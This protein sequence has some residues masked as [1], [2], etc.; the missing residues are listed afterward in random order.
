MNEE[1]SLLREGSAITESR[2]R[3]KFN[4]DRIVFTDESLGKSM[5]CLENLLLQ[6]IKGFL[7]DEEGTRQRWA[8]S[9]KITE[10][11][12]ENYLWLDRAT[13]AQ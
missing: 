12:G 4:E 10:F 8:V 11:Q 3:F 2:G 5:T 7:D 13:R 9:G 1:K 6:R